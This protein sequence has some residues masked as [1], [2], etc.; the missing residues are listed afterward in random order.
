VGLW[1]YRGDGGVLHEVELEEV[2]GEVKQVGLNADE[3][4]ALHILS[5]PEDGLAGEVW[6]DKL[7]AAGVINRKDR[8]GKERSYAAIK[9]SFYRVTK[10]LKGHCE[11]VEDNWK[12]VTKSEIPEDPHE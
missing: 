11:L 7:V 1:L 5:Q 4:Q 8:N 9:Q 3:G 2:E 6:R 12:A 10:G